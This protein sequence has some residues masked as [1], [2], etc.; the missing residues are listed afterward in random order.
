VQLVPLPQE[1]LLPSQLHWWFVHVLP[2]PQ[3]LV[4]QHAELA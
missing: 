4:L 3:S 2:E 1:R